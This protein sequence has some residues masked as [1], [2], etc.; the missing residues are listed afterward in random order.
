MDALKVWRRA[1]SAFD[2]AKTYENAVALQRA[3]RNM[4]IWRRE[5]FEV[6]E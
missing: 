3:K 2:D 6:I 4:G 1:Q 5:N